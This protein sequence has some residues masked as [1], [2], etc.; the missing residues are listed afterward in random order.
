MRAAVRG[1]FPPIIASGA[2]VVL[3]LLCLL[4]S[5]LN[6]NKSLGP[7]GAIGIVAAVL[8]MTLFLP[9]LLMVLGRYW[10]FPFVPRHDD[11][12]SHEKGVWGRIAAL[13]GRRPRGGW[14]AAALA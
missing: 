7:V 10:F 8:A 4:L 5:D 6:S 1:A 2:T 12:V 13:V 11:V 3:G 14:G 9:A